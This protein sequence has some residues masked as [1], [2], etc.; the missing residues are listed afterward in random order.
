VSVE[1]VTTR[2]GKQFQLLNLPYFAIS[3]VEKYV[4]WVMNEKIDNRHYK[5]PML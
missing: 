2:Q 5:A 1:A 4:E 3:Q